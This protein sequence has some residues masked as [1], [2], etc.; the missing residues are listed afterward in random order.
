M[1]IASSTERGGLLPREE[2]VKGIKFN[3]RLEGWVRNRDYRN[4]LI[5]DDGFVSWSGGVAEGSRLRFLKKKKGKEG[6]GF[7]GNGLWS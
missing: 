1:R 7:F 4:V 2:G 6:D 5:E 3:K